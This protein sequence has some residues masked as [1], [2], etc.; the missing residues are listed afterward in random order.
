MKYAVGCQTDM[1]E[2]QEKRSKATSIFLM[3]DLKIRV[4][5]AAFRVLEKVNRNWQKPLELSNS[6]H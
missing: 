2:P 3:G 4:A 6:F 5:V 1:Q